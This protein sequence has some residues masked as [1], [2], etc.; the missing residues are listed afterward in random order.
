MLNFRDNNG[1]FGRHDQQPDIR[2]KYKRDN[3]YYSA[4]NNNNNNRYLI[5][6]SPAEFHVSSRRSAKFHKQ[7]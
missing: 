2:I 1:Q 7:N 5:E 3:I 4:N 6:L